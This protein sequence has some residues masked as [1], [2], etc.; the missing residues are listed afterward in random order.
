MAMGI[1]MEDLP[2]I[3]IIVPTR[4]RP[5]DLADLL[6]TILNQSYPPLEVIIVDD[7]PV[8]SAQQVVNAFSLRFKSIN[9]MLKYVKG[10]DDGLP[11]ARNLGL[12]TVEGDAVL[13]LDD[14]TLLDQN[15]IKAIAIFLR[16]NP[17]A[18]GVQPNLRSAKNGESYGLARNCEN[19]IHKVLMLS[20]CEENSL[21]VRKSGASVF[22]TTLT[23]IINAQRLSGC[24]CCYK[25]EIFNKLRFDTNL[26]RWGF[27]EDLDFSYRVYRSNQKSLYAIP[28]AKIIHK[29]SGESRLPTKL[30]IYMVTMYWFYVF[31]KIIFK[32]SILNLVAF[33]WALTGNMIAVTGG[34]IIKRKPKREWW[35]LIYLLGSYATAFRNLRNIR[36]GKLEFFNNNL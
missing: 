8:A 4:D 12:K 28:N 14:D 18:I 22:P 20:Y 1:K 35:N 5:K 25:R 6:S 13:F 36:I 17:E 26:K 32:N 23:K 2:K 31:F 15:V 29:V 3:S 16:D 11:A 9:C 19:I 34:L 10:N 33:I 21:K 7:S 27:M 24:C 30:N